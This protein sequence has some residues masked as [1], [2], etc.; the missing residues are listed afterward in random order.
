MIMLSLW[1]R[2]ASESHTSNEK[3]NSS[4]TSSVPVHK[5]YPCA[6]LEVTVKENV[7]GVHTVHAYY[8]LAVPSFMK[9]GLDNI[10]PG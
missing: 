6:E 7:S 10:S 9:R 2:N 1:I 8:Q 3:F 4:Y 5:Q